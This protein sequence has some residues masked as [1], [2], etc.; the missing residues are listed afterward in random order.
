MFKKQLQLGRGIYPAF[1]L[2]VELTVI[3]CKRLVNFWCLKKLLHYEMSERSSKR[4]LTD[5]K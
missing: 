2:C 4:E 3:L 1:E 5:G